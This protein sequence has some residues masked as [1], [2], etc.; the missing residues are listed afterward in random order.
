[1]VTRQ[2]LGDVEFTHEWY[3]SLLD[4]LLDEGYRFRPFGR[5]PAPG[6]IF[7]RHDVDLSID[8]AFAM[9]RQEA[10]MEIQST[11][12][13]WLSSPLYNALERGQRET[14]RKIG[15]LGHDIGL[16][17][18]THTYWD[19]GEPSNSEIEDRVEQERSVLADLVPDLSNTVSFHRPPS[20]VLGQE[21]D[22]FQNTYADRYFTDIEYLADSNQR[23]RDEPLGIDGQTQS[24]Q[25]LTHPGLWGEQDGDFEHRVERSVINACRNANRRASEEFVNGNR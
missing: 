11:Y 2:M 19:D 23:W 22:G 16:H 21:F 13:I 4:Q 12:C 14:I 1:M 3:Q 15:N 8:D 9:A 7:L 24:L 17:F 5:Q 25:I 6:N 10:M 20:W 18:D